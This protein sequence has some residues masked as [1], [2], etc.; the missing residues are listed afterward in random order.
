MKL[1]HFFFL[2]AFLGTIAAKAQTTKQYVEVK[3]LVVYYMK[4]N[5]AGSLPADI[6]T[7][8]QPYF[9]QNTQFYWRNTS[10][11]LLVNYAQSVVISNE[12]DIVTEDDGGIPDSS[13]ANDLAKL[14][15]T[16]DQFDLVVVVSNNA[17]WNTHSHDGIL[18]SATMQQISWL[19]SNV[20]P[21][22][23]YQGVLIHE[24]NNMLDGCY[25]GL[26]DDAFPST[27]PGIGRFNGEYVP[28]S[29]TDQDFNKGVLRFW[30]RNNI[31]RLGTRTDGNP[32]GTLKTFTDTDNDGVPNSGSGLPIDEGTQGTSNTV[33]DTDGDGLTDLQE[34]MAAGF[35]GTNGANKADSDGDGINDN[36]DP[37]PIYP[38]K[39]SI[40]QGTLSI[41][42]DVTTWPL[43]GTFNYSPT[44]DNTSLYLSSD[45]N[46]FY[47][48][49]KTTST[50]VG[51]L[52]LYLD[53]NNDGLFYGKDNVHIILNGSNF[54]LI[55]LDDATAVPAG[56]IDDYEISNIS[57]TGF[58]G[59][60][61][62]GTGWTSYQLVIPKN[63]AYGLYLTGAEQI[64]MRI[65]LQNVGD[66]EMHTVVFE[67][68]DY[69]SFTLGGP[70]VTVSAPVSGAFLS[71]PATVTI[72]AAASNYTGT[73]TK[74]D[75]YNGTTLLGTANTSPY[76]YT[77]SNVA[78]GTYTIMAKATFSSGSQTSLP[79]TFTVGT[80][81]TPE[82]PVN[83]VNG[84]NYSYYEGTGWTAIPDF[85]TLTPVKSGVLTTIDIS[86]KNRDDDY[87]FKYTGY[88]NAP[89]DGLYTFYT[90]SDD[91]SNLY[92]GST[93]VVNNDGV[94]GLQVV[95]G[96]IAL[97]A[98]MHAITVAY[99]Q[100]GG[101]EIVDV[102][103]AY[104]AGGKQLIPASSLYRVN[105][106]PTVT[107]AAPANNATY[108][109][110]ATVTLTAT[111]SDADGTISKVEFYNGS[112]LLATKTASPYT[113]S[114]TSVPAAAYIITAKAYDNNNL[115]TTSSTANI[116]VTAAG[117]CPDPQYVAGTTYATGAKVKNNGHEYQCT[118][119]GWCS[120]ASASYYAPGTGSSWTSAWNDLGAC[121]GGT[122]AAPTV[123]L[124]AP[125]VLAYTAPA[126]VSIAANA[127]DSDG[128]I[129]KVEFY[130]GTTLLT[131]KTASPYTYSW[132]PVAAGNYAV[133]AKAYDNLN[134]VTTSA[135]VNI[136]VN[137]APTVSLTSPTVLSY[138]APATVSIA[139]N[140]AD[141]DGSISKVE[142]Y[143]GTTLLTTKTASPYTYSW[144][145]VAAGNYTI[146]AKAYDNLNAVTISAAINITVTATGTN[147]P[148][149]VSITAP[150]NNATFTPPAT[151]NI[152]ANAADADGSVSKVEF[153]N[154]ATLLGS[155][156]TAPYAFNWTNV[157]SG[158]Y[159]ITAKAYDNLNATTTSAVVAITVNAAPTVS[160]TSPTIL[161]YTA[162]AT[163]LLAANAADT[164]GSISKVEFYN[165]T[166]LI[167]TK[168]ASPYTFSWTGVAA[169]TYVITAKA[170]DN[171]NAAI[172]SSSVTITVA[173][174]GGTC[175]A[176]VWSATATYGTAGTAV[177]Y[178]GIKYL[179]NFWTSGDQP[180]LHNGAAGSGQPWTSQ[181]NCTS[182]LAEEIPVLV[183]I[184]YP[185]PSKGSFSIMAAENILATVI[186]T[187]GNEVASL[188]LTEGKNDVN[189]SLAS[190][191][192]FVK[193][194]TSVTKL[195]IE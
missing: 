8:M 42:A 47:F 104:N 51:R 56:S 181:G 87:A 167:A 50:N 183:N 161:S 157:A 134:A 142:F 22:R 123:S 84:I 143:Q 194:N 191:I 71:A 61:K 172:T 38:V 44:T 190:G 156:A 78:A 32:Y 138:T 3:A 65:E 125:T 131:T 18:N 110:P 88:F 179:N 168:T 107:L 94:H 97:K 29:G 129:S 37:E 124:T 171:S 109:A 103:Y 52:Q 26:G 149:T 4:T 175:T 113:Y 34:I 195:V 102:S 20:I 2:L 11:G 43:A 137:A 187:F 10:M 158:N 14:G 41:A 139:A 185:N 101:G 115:A 85:S 100:V 75:F 82:N 135:A 177:Q 74:I 178:N 35:T 111:A 150:A 106:A 30:G 117:S 83:A 48:G 120:S 49:L 91:G 21:D 9:A 122:N 40:P 55:E 54:D 95:S 15:F 70:V 136:A 27:Y 96:S 73:L 60:T 163:V 159:S 132:T 62:T 121:S 114:W 170:T 188:S 67:P 13:V 63:S 99:L 182:R 145:Q 98:G 164:D 151:V 152:T 128:S 17:G 16:N 58:T 36:V 25:L 141:A 57:P 148:P 173:A 144:T 76:T 45:N 64:G 24:T 89:S 162:P 165:N 77:W 7:Q 189:L 105:T 80:L 153:Y 1:K 108:T 169:G 186:N 66:S 130:Q 147:T 5:L 133:T 23:D 118:V 72:N 166:T 126:T 68:E 112:T 28:H 46:N 180:D 59:V 69:M 119:G 33:S 155:D 81:R 12:R 160:L 31:L 90:D 79:T 53:N 174:S 184:I 154:G 192:Y 176:Q 6:Q 39:A 19:G 127:A 193:F 93:L 92:I 116:T 86:P 146:T 140:A